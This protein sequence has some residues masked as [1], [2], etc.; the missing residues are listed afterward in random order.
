MHGQELHRPE[1]HDERT[2]PVSLSSPI[3]IRRNIGD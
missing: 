3:R 2:I 1:L